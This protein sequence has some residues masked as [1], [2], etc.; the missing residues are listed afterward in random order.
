MSQTRDT[1]VGN[2]SSTIRLLQAGTALSLLVVLSQFVTAGLMMSRIAARDAHAVGTIA[3]HV[4]T[5]LVVVAT[6]LYARRSGVRWP[7]ALAGV[8][9]LLTFVQAFMGSAGNLAVHVPLAL[10][11]AT[12]AVWLTAWA[13]RSADLL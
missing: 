2:P 5:G 13:F 1:L 11:I 9:F 6:V 10:G 4:T 8:V 7:A 12:G 3:L